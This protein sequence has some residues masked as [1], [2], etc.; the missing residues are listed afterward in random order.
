MAFS[1][2]PMVM[3]NLSSADIK[4]IKEVISKPFLELP[5]FIEPGVPTVVFFSKK[6]LTLV[7]SSIRVYL[8]VHFVSLLFRLRKKSVS[9][10]QLIRS[11][12]KGLLR[13]MTYSIIYGF[14]GPSSTT[15]FRPVY[16]MFGNGWS[17][18]LIAAT[19]SSSVLLES[20]ARLPEM[21]LYV[22][23][24]WFQGF[25]HSL[26]K[27]A[28]VPEVRHLEKIIMGLALGIISSLYYSST[29]SSGSVLNVKQF[30][31]SESSRL[32]K[33]NSSEESGP[34]EAQQVSIDRISCE[35]DLGQNEHSNLVVEIENLGD[36]KDSEND[37]KIESFVRL[38]LGDRTLLS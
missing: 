29:S 5:Q 1:I 8:P 10:R 13:S 34:I 26:R 15:I 3:K 20:R 2:S 27:R 31:R 32:A 12:L 16:N 36:I 4:L 24:Q 35:S 28:Y 30:E 22:L 25:G 37:T 33:I 18:I 9:K 19:L 23:S 6:F 21:S 17:A 14:A 7:S 11:F 38:L